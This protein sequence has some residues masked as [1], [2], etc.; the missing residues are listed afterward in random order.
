MIRKLAITILLMLAAGEAMAERALLAGLLARSPAG[1]NDPAMSALALEACLKLA[2]SLD[3]TGAK[4]A[5]QAAKIE[6][7]NAEHIALQNQINA[8]LDQLGHYNAQQMAA[9]QRRVA[10]N[11]DV[12]RK[13]RGDRPAHQ[14]DRQA[15]DDAV[16]GF[17]RNCGGHFRAGDLAAARAKFGLN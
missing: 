6:R 13:L 5:G 10:H 11:D 8:E 16:A 17:G 7:L 3:R 2:T 12:E 14:K 15:Y 1:P 9:F 4:V